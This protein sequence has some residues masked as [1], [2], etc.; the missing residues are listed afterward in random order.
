L[1][2]TT[3]CQVAVGIIDAHAGGVGLLGNA[4]GPLETTI[5]LIGGTSNCHMAASPEPVFVPGVWG[6]YYG[7]MVPGFWL[8][9]GGQS[10]AGSLIDYV[11]EDSSESQAL[12]YE[13]ERAGKTVYQLLNERLKVLQ[14]FESFSDIAYLTRDL[15]VLDYHLGNR[16]PFADPHARGVVEGIGLDR[17]QAYDT[18]LYLATVQSVAYGTR[19]IIDALNAQ[20]FNIQTILATG[21]GTKNPVWLQQHADAT[22]LQV[23]LGDESESVL[24]GAAMLGARASGTYTSLTDAMQT[25]ANRG[26]TIKPNPATRAY[27]DA[28][29]E[30]YKRLYQTQR[31]NRK[32]MAG[33]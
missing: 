32:T 9:E 33:V 10:A 25:M 29:Y 16:S 27:H 15:H 22:G 17:S 11:I 28:K 18:K 30:V 21:G 12:H 13:A 23:I 20:G 8:T 14:A 5:A 4:D 1:G 31:E 19:A 2:L 26:E 7:A 24:L 6:P 3:N